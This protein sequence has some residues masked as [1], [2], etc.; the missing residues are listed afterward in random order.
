MANPQRED[1]HIDIA[2]EI[3]DKLCQYRIPGQEWQILWVVLRKT[4]G[5]VVKD[6]NGNYVRARNGNILKKKK[7]R[8]PFSQFSKSTGIPRTKCHSLLESLINKN[9]VEKSVPHKGDRKFI[10]Y[11]F[12]KNYEEWKVSPIKGTFPKKGTKVSPIKGTSKEEKKEKFKKR[13]TTKILKKEYFDLVNLLVEKMLLNDPKA[14]VP[15]TEKKRENWANDFRKLIELD[16]RS[17]QEIREVL[18]WCQEDNFWKS[19]I[20]SAGSFRKRYPQ[21]RLKMEGEQKPSKPDLA[22]E[23]RKEMNR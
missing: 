12:Q 5:W 13:L 10:T 11:G 7:D 9:I 23:T 2:N 6:K 8:I 16:G 1:G 15:N 14:K 17:I 3:V 18:I 4:W 22:E 19:N 20:L 21:L